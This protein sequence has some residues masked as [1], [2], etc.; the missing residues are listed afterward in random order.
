VNKKTVSK[1]LSRLIQ[2]GPAL[3]NFIDSPP[4]NTSTD[5]EDSL[6][7]NNLHDGSVRP[8]SAVLRY[9]CVDNGSCA[10]AYPTQSVC[11]D[12]ETGCAPQ[13]TLS[14]DAGTSAARLFN[15]CT[16]LHGAQQ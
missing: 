16:L 3:D 5:I 15:T 14:V 10:N 9:L 6:A 2:K 7:A 1:S 13:P 12:N 4:A 8:P 11:C